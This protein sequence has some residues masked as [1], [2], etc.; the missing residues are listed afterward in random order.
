MVGLRRDVGQ[1]VVYTLTVAK[2]HTYFVGT[3]QVLVHNCGVPEDPAKQDDPQA[4]LSD[5]VARARVKP[6]NYKY[7]G[8]TYLYESDTLKEATRTKLLAD[9]KDGVP[10]TDLGFPDFSQY[11]YKTGDGLTAKVQIQMA[12][13]DRI[14]FARADTAMGF[15]KTDRP[16]GWTWHHVEDRTT[17]IL[18]PT[19][20]H[21]NVGHSG[22]VWVIDRLGSLP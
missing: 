21:D 10:F 15:G 2:D 7:R 9:Y 12:G 8:S 5:L 17:M 16:Y 6:L 1:A 13:K 14:D 20:L 4:I 11:A 22:G 19:F 18:V 3:D